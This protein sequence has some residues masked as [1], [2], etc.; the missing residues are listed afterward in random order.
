MLTRDGHDRQCVQD[1][2]IWTILMEQI[3]HGVDEVGGRLLAAQR[4]GK[5]MARREGKFSSPAGVAVDDLRC[6]GVM[7]GAAALLRPAWLVRHGLKAVRHLHGVAV[8]AAWGDDRTA[9]N[10]VPPLL[11]PFDVGFPSHHPTSSEGSSSSTAAARMKATAFMSP[12]RAADWLT[13]RATSMTPHFF[14]SAMPVSS[15]PPP[16]MRA[17]SLSP[18]ARFAWSRT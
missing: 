16:F 13:L 5:H 12:L 18:R 4:R 1:P 11:G 7:A 15:L 9:D 17:R 10:R 2:F 14:A 3:A 6:P 8:R